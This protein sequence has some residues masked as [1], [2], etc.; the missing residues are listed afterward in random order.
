VKER[1]VICN[2]EDTDGYGYGFTVVFSLDLHLFVSLSMSEE[3]LKTHRQVATN[4]GIRTN[5]DYK[6]YCD[7]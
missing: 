2:E 5:L 7:G 6:F 4:V 1:L 3:L